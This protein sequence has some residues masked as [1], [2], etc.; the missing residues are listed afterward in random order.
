MARILVRFTHSPYQNSHAID[1]LEFAMS[2]TNY[3]HKVSVL[4]EGDAVWMWQSNQQP[5]AGVKNIQKK[6]RALPLFEVEPCYVSQSAAATHCIDIPTSQCVLVDNARI[7]ELLKEATHVV[8][9]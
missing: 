1:G 7:V 6:L 3:G 5:P 9:F 2:A 8:T 4:F